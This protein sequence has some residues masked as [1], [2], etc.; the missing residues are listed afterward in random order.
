MLLAERECRL[1]LVFNFGASDVVEVVNP[2]PNLTLLMWWKALNATAPQASFV[3]HE[4]IGINFKDLPEGV[5]SQ[6]FSFVPQA[7]TVHRGESNQQ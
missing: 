7:T 5:D 3:D 2:N 1:V 4:T 6:V